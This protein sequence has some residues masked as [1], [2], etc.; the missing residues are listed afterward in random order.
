[1][2][3]G[4]QAIPIFNLAMGFVP[5][6]VVWYIV[7][8]WRL[9]DRQVIY[10]N[11]RMLLQL[12]LVGYVLTY[13]FSAD[14]G[15]IV[16]VVLAIMLLAAS[17]IALRPLQHKGTRVYLLVLGAIGLGG[18]TTLALV[19]QVVLELPTWYQPH[20]MIPLAGMIFS[21]CMNTISL[22][23]ER[24][25]SEQARAVD[26]TTA[27]GTALNAALIPQINA[28]LAVGI[29]ALPGMMTGQILAGVSPLIA[30]Q[31]QIVVMCMIFGSAGIAA[32]C[33]LKFVDR[34]QS[35]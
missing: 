23:A 14:R 28:L 20:Y 7:R 21:N 18:V 15:D 10:A 13:I 11:F 6:V 9:P 32:A 8:S 1:M 12:L 35:V 3:D 22:A 31:Y 33:Y 30:A 34:I 25:E 17:W 24:Y 4:V 26:S 2:G 27:R 19:T 5:V 16:L 29:V